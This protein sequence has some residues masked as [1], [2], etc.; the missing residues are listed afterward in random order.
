M[1]KESTNP[2]IEDCGF[3]HVTVMT[4][5]V[6]ASLRLYRDVL[7]MEIAYEFGP[8][9]IRI[10]LLD[11]GD[12]SHIEL[13]APVEPPPEGPAANN[14][15]GHLALATTNTVA[16]LEHVRQAGYEITVEPQVIDLRTGEAT[17]AFSRVRAGRRSSFSRRIEW[18][19]ARRASEACE[20]LPPN[21]SRMAVAARR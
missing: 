8:P 7:G 6:E 11:V 2:V 15:L 18:G 5:D 19:N 21:G 10:I 4:R 1:T 13:F 20:G 3:H 9:E 12:G 16:A 14:P 17:I